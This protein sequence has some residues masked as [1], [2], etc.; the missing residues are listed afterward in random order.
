MNICCLSFSLFYVT[1]ATDEMVYFSIRLLVMMYL[2]LIVKGNVKINLN[3]AQ[4]KDKITNFIV[5]I[6]V[7]NF[8]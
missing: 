1:F 6:L 3:F 8:Y 2:L 4:K 7:S 5:R